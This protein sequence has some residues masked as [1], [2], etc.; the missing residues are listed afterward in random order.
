M[1]RALAARLLGLTAAEAL[2]LRQSNDVI[3][4][5]RMGADAPDVNHFKDGKGPFPGLTSERRQRA[6]SVAQTP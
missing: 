2:A 4:R 3:F 6:R 5:I 1:N